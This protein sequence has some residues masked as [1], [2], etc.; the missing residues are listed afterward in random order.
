M[1]RTTNWQPLGNTLNYAVKPAAN[2]LKF[3]EYGGR[4]LIVYYANF[5]KGK[6]WM[7]KEDFLC[8]DQAQLD[9][10]IENLKKM[11]AD[12]DALADVRYA[13]MDNHEKIADGIYETTYSNGVK[14]RVDYNQEKAEII[15]GDKAAA[16]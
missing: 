7:G 10:S 2:R 8:D 12:Y 16:L 4:P 15:R 13:F 6:N 14:I 5:A 3:F 1:S 9:D 11:Y